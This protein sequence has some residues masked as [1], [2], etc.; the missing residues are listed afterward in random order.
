LKLSINPTACLRALPESERSY[1]E[2]PAPEWMA[3][4][5][6][7]KSFSRYPDLWFGGKVVWGRIVQVNTALFSAGD[8]DL[9]GDVVF[10]P[11]GQLG[12]DELAEVTGRLYALKGTTPTDAALRAV[13]DHLTNEYA[14]AFGR[15]VPKSISHHP[16][17]M[18]T[19]LFHRK[20]LP[21]RKI[22]Q[23]Y[24]PVLINDKFPGVVM[25]LPSRWWPDALLVNS[26]GNAH[27]MN[28][29]TRICS[30]CQEPM[31]KLGLAAHY[32]RTVEIDVCEPC[33]LIWFDDTESTRLAGP[34]LADLVRVIHNAMQQPRSLQ[35][36]PQSLPCPICA[37]A[38]KRVS[39]ITRYG[40]IAQLE[41]GEKHGAYQSFAL[42]LTE[43]GYFRPF[44]WA[45]I[46]Q[47][48]E[49]GKRLSCFNCGATLES[50]PHG[51]CQ[52]CKSP[53]GLI[54]PARLASAID[55]ERVAEPLR[56]LPAV[57]QTACP[58]CGGAI[59]LNAE[60]VCPHCRAVV[61]PADT[62]RA[63]AASE[64]V[65]SQVRDNYAKQTAEVSTRKLE[66]V[67]RS[68]APVYRMPG[69]ESLRRGAIILVTLISLGF[70]FT[71][72]AFRS[73]DMT[74]RNPDGRPLGMSPDLYEAVKE[75]RR[76]KEMAQIPHAPAGFVPREIEVTSHDD[77]RLTVASQSKQRVKVAVS[78]VYP[79]DESRCKMKSTDASADA[80]GAATFERS[81]ES[82][83]FAPDTCT[84]KLLI[85]GK[86]EYRV[87]SLDESRYLFKSDSAF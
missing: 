33:S 12:P 63:L 47:V 65:A 62:E 37:Q 85:Y 45:D 86:K 28:T 81:G 68:E 42:F 13:A 66:Y 2:I 1:L 74:E 69:S 49:S 40:R 31:R 59:Q 56:L 43:K 23:P 24:F 50:R 44:T 51:E 73:V 78:L 20:H 3:R 17:L 36:L 67:G 83:M 41:C 15:P 57:E 64:T 14:R 32:Q 7:Q 71:K 22:T 21:G 76:E 77:H 72:I 6:L 25:A 18:S 58:C 46:K 82:H 38:L 55:S 80:H 52:Y 10:D 75:A 39:N 35:P 11:T 60:M 9:P 29:M 30:H 84:P 4:D 54:D 79:Q 27:V 26:G 70:I 16:L 61:R 53:V 19:V 8:E 87:W 48:L 34:G 5:P